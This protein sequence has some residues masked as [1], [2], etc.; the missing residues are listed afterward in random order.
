MRVAPPVVAFVAALAVGTLGAGLGFV[1]GSQIVAIGVPVLSM[2]VYMAL[3]SRLENWGVSRDQFADSAYF[4]GF[5]F[6]LVGLTIALLGSKRLFR[7]GDIDALIGQFALAL[8]TTIVGLVG[9]MVLGGFSTSPAESLETA[10]EAL[11]DAANRLR[12]NLEGLS[13]QL[14]AH[15]RSTE[16]ALDGALRDSRRVL[17]EATEATVYS[18]RQTGEQFGTSSGEVQ[19][20]IFQSVRTTGE[21]LDRAAQELS[22]KLVQALR[23]FKA[24]L[25]DVPRELLKERLV[26]PLEALASELERLSAVTLA[27]KTEVQPISRAV[28]AIGVSLAAL[29]PH[30]K[31]LE[32]DLPKIKQLPSSLEETAIASKALEG[33]LRSSAAGIGLVAEQVMREGR[34]I[35][36]LRTAAARN[37]EETERLR[38]KLAGEVEAA[39]EALGAMA[40][41]LV[42]AAKYVRK[43]LRG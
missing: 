37:L 15:T 36:E 40:R 25:S 32:E 42:D 33:Q 4:L 39:A 38:K 13:A 10:E 23:D 9:R 11:A 14:T 30:F 21:T 16:K 22:G 24:A 34:Q 3:A 35:E 17:T 18:I 28:K 29:P 43:E 1:V 8:V 12:V 19:K 7:A 27:V 20:A 5:L 26:P 2:V 6:T 41:E 31:T